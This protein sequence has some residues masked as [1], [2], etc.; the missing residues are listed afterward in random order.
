[1]TRKNSRFRSDLGFKL[2]GG[3][4]LVGFALTAGISVLSINSGSAALTTQASQ[5]LVA[6]RQSRQRDIEDFFNLKHRQA[7][8]YARL[9]TAVEAAEDFTL[10]FLTRP[11]ETAPANGELGKFYESTFKTALEAAGGE[12]KG[13]DSHLPQS[14][15]GILLQSDYIANNP[16]PVGAK[17]ELA[18]A[19][20]DTV[21]DRVHERYHPAMRA[22]V[23]DFG[24]YDLFIFDLRGNLVYSV[25]KET[26]FATNFLDGPHAG[27]GLATAYRSALESADRNA[28]YLVDFS[29]YGPSYGS[30]QSF[31]SAS[32][33]RGARKVGVIALQLPVDRINEIMSGVEG[34]GATGETFLIGPD[35]KFRTSSRF[36]GS[37]AIL[38]STAGP[39]D[40]TGSLDEEGLSRLDDY[41]GIEALWSFA[42]INIE[43][44]DWRIVAKIDYDEITAPAR[45]LRKRIAL[46]AVV[47]LALATSLGYRLL[48]RSVVRP[49]RALAAGAR[50][51]RDGDYAHRVD[52]VGDDELGQLGTD[53]NGMSAALQSEIEKQR[54][55]QRTL[56]ERE[57]QMRSIMQNI[58]GATYRYEM[59]EDWRIAFMSDGIEALTG[60]PAEAFVGEGGITLESITTSEDQH[61][62]A[63][64][65]V[66]EAF[67]KSGELSIEHRIVHRDGSVNWVLQQ[68]HLTFD[69]DG[70]PHYVD[71]SLFDIN[72][73]KNA[74]RELERA[75]QLMTGVFDNTDA[76]IYVKDLEGRYVSVN[77]KWLEAC[78]VPVDQV[79]EHLPSDFF[80]AEL[81][82]DIEATDAEVR[83]SCE[84][85]V[86]QNVIETPDGPRTFVASKF[87]LTD[88][89]GQ[90]F[91]TAGVSIDVTDILEAEA[92]LHRAQQLMQSVFDNTDAMIFIKDLDLRYMMVNRKWCEIGSLE[93]GDVIGKAA[94]EFMPTDLA[95]DVEDSDAEVV[96]TLQPATSQFPVSTSSGPRTF[97]HSK[98]PMLDADGNLYAIAGVSTDVTVMKEVENE[99]REAREQAESANRTKSAF[100]ANMSHELRTPMNAIIGY[101]EMLIEE[102]EDL[103]QEDFIPDL[104]KIQGAG[105]HLLELINDILDL[106]KIEAGRIE[107]F[108]E[109][110]DVAAL[111][112]EV[113][114]TVQPLVQKNG[115]EFAVT[116]DAAAGAISGDVTRIRQCLLNLLSNAAKFTEK[117]VVS[118]D[119][120]REE[121]KIRFAVGDSGI[122]IAPDKLA[123]L[124]EEFTQADASTTRKYG[125][126]GLGLS[127]TRRLARI[128]GGDVTVTSTVGEGS[129]FTLEVPLSPPVGEEQ[130]DLEEVTHDDDTNSGGDL[131]LVI[132]DDPQARDL[133]RRT[134]TKEGYRVIT[135]A[136]GDEGLELAEQH[137][138]M[139]IT[140]DVMMPGKDGWSVLRELKAND[141]LA[142]IPVILS[143]MVDDRGL[144]Y[145]LGA[146]EYLTKPL[147][148]GKLIAILGKYQC[149]DPPC[150]VLVVEDD[151][152]IRELQRRALEAEG[153]KV[154]EAENGEE[155]IRAMESTRPEL[156]MLDL[157]MPVMDGF[158]FVLEMRARPEW[159]DIPIIVVTAKDLSREEREVLSGGVEAI[160][161][162]GGMSNEQLL[163]MVRNTLAAC[164]TTPA[165]E[166]RDGNDIAR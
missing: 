154:I 26:D 98:F 84:L 135:A 80:A 63:E 20:N 61:L 114:V 132:D 145:T 109:E 25:F 124:F 161:E 85:N 48:Q 117:G 17:D 60:Y 129:C 82:A 123:Q 3:A 128:M 65:A 113:E 105:R 100:L 157:M 73:R 147:D 151:P 149:N 93:R 49:V 2:L 130:H 140:L 36:D 74:E 97:V 50:L 43:G 164:R 4:L 139:A 5:S 150:P 137:R 35:L 71:G 166:N 72:M 13:V 7:L 102:A 125:G 156:V 18:T 52:A 95:R 126:T 90:L 38:N 144:G 96:R 138:P 68:A 152:Q 142:G 34:L 58:P 163:T 86:S 28:T 94:N 127:I 29:R 14:D 111:T 122:G 40:F 64:G 66:R 148:R 12:W 24:F 33:F 88:A 87:P 131:V 1:M 57:S 23:D 76:M 165:E 104:E 112:K 67:G 45:E 55:M 159:R 19:D 75:Q 143:T 146:A 116:T 56:A 101:S 46:F 91:A 92:E 141:E 99:L 120:S 30:S 118:L 115:N 6:V 133:L 79:I 155:G 119:V 59:Q 11:R 108:I 53:F 107:L 9:G 160:F 31:I 77:R 69:D 78:D 39:V 134:L 89:A 15:S 136:D 51:I 47:L 27:S 10:A 37:A 22:L 42:P 8:S 32:L 62:L 21:Y 158:D 162:K 16:H 106:S 54:H 153:W 110:L 83:N 70:K 41:R 81:A 44:L 121:E 103:E